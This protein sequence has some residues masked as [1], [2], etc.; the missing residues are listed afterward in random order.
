MPLLAIEDAKSEEHYKAVDVISGALDQLGE[1]IQQHLEAQ[2]AEWVHSTEEH[3]DL[4]MLCEHAMLTRR[5]SEQVAVSTFQEK[6]STTIGAEIIT[7]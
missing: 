6:G 5:V 3:K 7:Y 4:Y 2:Q 1:Q